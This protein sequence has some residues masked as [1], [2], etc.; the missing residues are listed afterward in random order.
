[1]AESTRYVG[2]RRPRIDTRDKVIGATRY[3]G[4][5]GLP[6]LLHARIVPSHYA[7]AMIRGVDARRALAIPGVVA[8][9]TA[10][11]LHTTWHGPERRFEPLAR[12][13]VV[14]VGQPVALVVAETEAAA[15]DAVAVVEVDLESLEPVI[16]V[17]AASEPGA[18]LARVTPSAG[19]ADPIEGNV[20]DRLHERRGDVRAAFERCAAI[21]EGRF[22]V[23]WAYQA[24]IEP[25]VATATLEADG[26]L[27]VTA[28]VQGLFFA[29]NELAKLVGLPSSRVRVSALPIGGAFGGKQVVIEPLVVCAAIRLRAPIRL[30]LDRR[31][32][33]AAGNPSQGM[34]IDARIGAD[35]TGRL[36]A[37]EARITYDGGAY[38]D[39]SWQ[40]FAPRLITGPYRWAAF[41][42]EALGVRTNRF[43]AGNYRGPS[44]PQGVFA[45]ESLIDELAE[46]LGIDPIDFR[47]ANLVGEGD[48][49][50]NGVAWPPIGAGAC[51]D[52]L[53]DHPEWAKRRHLPRG[54]GIGLA[55]GVWAGSMQPAAAS[56]RLE[57]DGSLT[58]I[59]GA[60]DISGTAS[61]FAVIAA[62]AF[63]IAVEDVTV[64]TADTSTAP[65]SPPTNASAITY[66]SGRAVQQAAAEA[67]ER[68]LAVAATQL[69]IAP[70]DLE[71]VDGVVQPRG[72]PD[73]GRPVVDL[74]RQLSE[75]F[76]APW[77]PVEGHAA[78]AHSVLAPS[79]VG[80]LAHVRVD[81]ETGT[82]EVLSYVVV[83]DVGRA[84]N[85][86]L[87]EGQMRGG[88][89]QSI[90]RALW[91]EL[92]HDDQGQLL[93]GTFLDYAVPRASMLP[94]I[95]TM[96]VELPAPEGPF[97]AKG[98]GEAPI[99]AGPAAVANAIAA[100]THVRLRELPMTAPRV[101]AAL[102][103]RDEA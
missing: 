39:D 28:S 23:G 61:G 6:G 25:Q 75:S 42:V 13:E 47:S 93:T 71:I 84:L 45:L 65:Q 51:L 36:E 5:L 24:A 30:V 21:V 49:Q 69:E 2:V 26:T 103:S 97:G 43:G 80:H 18:P 92:V 33:I 8:V 7:H 15:A 67:R 101:W 57:P 73:A 29:R 86:D 83:Q 66:S 10:A 91:E 12:G 37:L 88:A 17:L 70:E 35:K 16:D 11:D 99:L 89:V 52:R 60:V 48:L 96:I 34:V 78:I 98:I 68:L 32:D 59:T 62:E 94:P 4:D 53:R 40:W 64:V 77:P 9:L 95:E 38:P 20:F 27:A 81:E 50:A 46:R 74:A 85:P 22:R 1:M 41:D 79:T 63:G 44:G 55:I 76:D 102:R 56:C 19:D 87:V 54:E 90:G 100:A 72:S 58:V 14:F 3:G 82:V 31:D